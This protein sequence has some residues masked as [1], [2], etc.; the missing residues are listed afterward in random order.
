MCVMVRVVCS[1]HSGW[2]VV[3]VWRSHQWPPGSGDTHRKCPVA[4]ATDVTESVCH[5]EGGRPLR[6]VK[7]MSYTTQN[8]LGITI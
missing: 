3:R 4:T 6:W 1:S 2:Q 8:L 7:A 5:Q